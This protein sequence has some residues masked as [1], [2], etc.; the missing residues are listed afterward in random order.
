VEIGCED[1]TVSTAFQRRH[2]SRAS[3][4]SNHPEWHARQSGGFILRDVLCPVRVRRGGMCCRDAVRCDSGAHGPHERREL[5][6]EARQSLKRQVFYDGDRREERHGEVDFH[7]WRAAEAILGGG[8]AKVHVFLSRSSF[9]RG[10][11][12]AAS[13]G[14]WLF[15]CD[16]TPPRG[17]AGPCL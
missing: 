10:S 9:P 15:G 4:E 6:R 2:P 16:P 3:K 12:L 1:E 8:V 5:R 13:E 14:Y 7:A 17:D 11:D